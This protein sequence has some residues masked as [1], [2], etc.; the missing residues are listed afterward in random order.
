MADDD[1]RFKGVI[2]FDECCS[3]AVRSL[4]LSH[5][6][7]IKLTEMGTER[8]AKIAWEFALDFCRT[9]YGK[10]ATELAIKEVLES[11]N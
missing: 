1:Y 4:R 8:M 3:L 2:P 6:N 7:V 9:M 10:E 11:E 5:G